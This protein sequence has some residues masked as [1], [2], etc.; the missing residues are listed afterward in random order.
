MTSTPAAVLG[1]ALVALATPASLDRDDL[2]QALTTLGDAQAVLDAVKV[3]VVGELVSRSVVAGPDNPVTA[4]GQSNPAALVA[5]RWRIPLRAARQFCDVGDATA[6]RTSLVGEHLA[7]RLPVLAEAIGSALREPRLSLSIDHAGVIAR[8][9]QKAAVAC[10]RSDLELGERLLVAHAP[11]L[12]VAEL[13]TVAGQVRDRLDNDGIVPRELRQRRRR[14]LTIST[15]DDGMTHVDWY[16]DPESAGYVVSA[17][18][19]M[20][21]H[22]LRGVRF[23]ATSD[24]DGRAAGANEPERAAGEVDD[25]PETRTLAQLRSDAATDVFRH[26]AACTDPGANGRPPVTV[27]VRIDWEALRSGRGAGEIDGVPSTVSVRTVRRMAADASVIPV[28]LGGESEV[29]DLGRARRLFSRA[30]RIALAE[31]DGGCA[32][33][34]CPH[35]PS[36]TEAHHIRWWNAHGG[37][38]DLDNG[39]LLCGGHHHRIH[40]DGWE[41]RIHEGL[42]TFI[43]PAHVDPYRRPRTGGRLRLRVRPAA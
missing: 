10:S 29:L 42:P 18:D 32:W 7:P 15:T 34:G 12:S 39:V 16:L 37:D 25:A 21:D 35:P 31:R 17:I 14:S 28:V 4:A 36:Y 27:V 20:V 24:V 5:D 22:E 26:L 1:D 11:N 41:I 23:R 13:R 40:D 30:Q 3:R 33:P 38:T 2:L 8:E 6:E 9:L 19:A 43:P